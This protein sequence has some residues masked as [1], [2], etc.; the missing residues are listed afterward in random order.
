M[1]TVD[2]SGDTVTELFAQEGGWVRQ[3]NW[4][5]DGSQIIFTIDQ[6]PAWGAPNV[7]YVIDADGT[8]LRPIIDTPDIKGEAY[9]VP[10]I[11]D[12]DRGGQP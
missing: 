3:P 12:A 10:D 11:R 8:G 6:S 9:W 5:P 1:L 4:S 7:L 2:P